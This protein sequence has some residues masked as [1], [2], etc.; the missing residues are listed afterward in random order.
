MILPRIKFASIED[1]IY[2]FQ[3]SLTLYGGVQ[4]PGFPQGAKLATWDALWVYLAFLALQAGLHV[5]LPGK[6][7]QGVMLRNGK[8]LSYK[9]TG[10]RAD[11]TLSKIPSKAMLLSTRLQGSSLKE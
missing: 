2:I 10:M 1:D 11:F 7:E 4:A 8:R 9:F 5:L 3:G 6:Q